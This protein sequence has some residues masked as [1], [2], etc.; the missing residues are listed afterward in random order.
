MILNLDSLMQSDA[1]SNKNKTD[2]Q[3]MQNSGICHHCALS[4]KWCVLANCK[5]NPRKKMIWDTENIEEQ[6]NSANIKNKIKFVNNVDKKLN[7]VIE[8]EF[9]PTE[10]TFFVK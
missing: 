2:M 7:V 10:E 6:K 5:I 1:T 9:L 4:E 8:N 3:A